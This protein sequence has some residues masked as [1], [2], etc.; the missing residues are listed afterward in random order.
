M[1]VWGLYSTRVDPYHSWEL[2][3]V[4]ASQELAETVMGNLWG[5]PAKQYSGLYL[6]WQDPDDPEFSDLIVRPLD[7]HG[8]P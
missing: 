7:V 3:A 6:W 8:L 2:L 5:K 4:F 1:K